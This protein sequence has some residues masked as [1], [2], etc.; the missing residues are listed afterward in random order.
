M[1]RSCFPC[2]LRATLRVLSCP[3]M[4][5][6]FF[7]YFQWHYSD[8]LRLILRAWQNCLKFNLNY[9]SLPL[10]LRTLF[11]HWH[12]YSYSYG[13]GFDP[14]R[15]FEVFTFNMTSR[16]IGAIIRVCCIIIGLFTELFVFLTGALVFLFWLLLPFLII[17]G[18]FYGFKLLL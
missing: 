5:N 13:R 3:P 9:W 17:A 11:S 12:K 15:Y 1:A 4:N 8:N 18:I 7:L 16:I 10:L 6:I 2:G 14:K